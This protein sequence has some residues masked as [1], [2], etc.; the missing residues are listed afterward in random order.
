MNTFP[1]I[2]SS[3]KTSYKYIDI[4]PEWIIHQGYLEYLNGETIFKSSS[5]KFTS[6]NETINIWFSF[7]FLVKQYFVVLTCFFNENKENSIGIYLYSEKTK[8]PF[9]YFQ[10]D[11]N[12]Q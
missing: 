8:S 11:K 9:K 5:C 6:K 4:K 2:I 12:D 7:L 3:D 10:L 1:Q